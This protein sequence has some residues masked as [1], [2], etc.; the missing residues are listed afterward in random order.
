MS[1]TPYTTLAVSADPNACWSCHPSTDVHLAAVRLLGSPLC[2]PLLE[3]G[4]AAGAL[5]NLGGPSIALMASSDA[6]IIISDNQ[7]VINCHR[8]AACSSREPTNG[9]YLGL[10]LTCESI[11]H[12]AA[13]T[14]RISGSYGGTIRTCRTVFTHVQQPV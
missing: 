12:S 9:G 10:L 13:A 4:S 14:D 2:V 3:S 1:N 5:R 6:A 11:L 8:L 7:A